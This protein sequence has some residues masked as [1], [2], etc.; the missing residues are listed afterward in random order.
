M[1]FQPGHKNL[2]GE[3]HIGNLERVDPR[4]VE[5]VHL[6]RDRN[7]EVLCDQCHNGVFVRTFT[8]DV[9]MDF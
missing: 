4:R 7:A 8:H 1:V 9:R 5:G 3:G 6:C 2:M